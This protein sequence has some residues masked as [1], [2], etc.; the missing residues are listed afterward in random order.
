[1]VALAD[2]FTGIKMLP[3]FIYEGSFDLFG[4]FALKDI[5]LTNT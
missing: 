3:D 4:A 1:M 2:I 5:L